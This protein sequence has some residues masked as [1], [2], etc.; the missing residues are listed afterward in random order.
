MAVINESFT[1]STSDAEALRLHRYY[2]G[3]LQTTLK[4]PIRSFDDFAI[5]Y[6]PGVAAPCRAIHA[7]ADDVYEYTNKGNTIAIV[8]DG[9]RV[10]GLG[11]IGPAAGL[12]VME[13][14]ALLFKYLGGVDAVPLCLKTNGPEE[15]IRAVEIL[16][17]SFGGINLEDISQ[18]N[19]FCV[20]DSLRASM[21]IP[22]WHDDQQGSATVTL[23]G[24]LGALELV[25]KQLDRVRIVL[26][27]IGAANV[28]NYRLLLSAGAS[29]G[30]IIACDR[31]GILHRNRED[32]KQEQ[33]VFLDKWRICCESNADQIVGG[34][35]EALKGA[36]IC[37]AFSSPGPGIIRPEW[38]RSMAPDAVV[39]A[40]ANPVPEVWPAIARE[41]G[42]RIVATGRSDFPNQVNNSLVFPGIFRGT[43]DVRAA[44]I[45]EGMAMAAA[46]ELSRVAREQGLRSDRIL[47]PMDDL[48]AILRVSVATAMRAQNEGIA[49]L[50]K[51][52]DQLREQAD[53]IIRHARAMTDCLMQAGLI[54]NGP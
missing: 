48:E 31:K 17:P 21:S 30:R 9:S 16:E 11:K 46:R 42:A 5:W 29:A 50:T 41:G 13:G 7:Q 4:C 20:L 45:S 34:I 24:L 40:C 2:R 1:K 36:D 22:V 23:A 14:K 12:P 51:T 3:K 18:P 15:L 33:D 44:K 49:R 38:I 6:T 53:A 26:V 35:P 25:G 47:P 43:L 39:F 37:L 8:S 52:E 28:A 10:L 19:C 32:L 54:T 27:G